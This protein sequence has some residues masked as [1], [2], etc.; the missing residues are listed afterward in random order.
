MAEN[1]QLTARLSPVKRP[2]KVRGM[3]ML[4]PALHPNVPDAVRLRQVP[5]AAVAAGPRDSV[6]QANLEAV[7]PV[8]VKRQEEWIICSEISVALMREVSGRRKC[9]VCEE[10]ILCGNGEFRSEFWLF[11]RC[12][13]G[14]CQRTPDEARSNIGMMVCKKCDKDFVFKVVKGQRTCRRQN[15]RRAV[16]VS[17]SR[18]KSKLALMQLPGLSM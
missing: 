7:P 5:S 16:R 14:H 1:S 6:L 8:A 4:S 15:C 3:K 18:I 12:L 10:V 9:I 2:L 17:E 13:G 11:T